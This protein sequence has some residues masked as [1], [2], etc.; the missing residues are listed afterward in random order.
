MDIIEDLKEYY[1]S[2]EFLQIKASFERVS[3]IQAVL[4]TFKFIPILIPGLLGNMVITIYFLKISMNRVGRMS[5]YHFL[6]VLLAI[7]D[8]VV[9]IL[10][11][12]SSILYNSI[13][14]QKLDAIVLIIFKEGSTTA[15]YWVL[16]MLSY[17]RY[18]RIVHHFKRKSKKRYV[19]LVWICLW[20][21]CILVHLPIS[22]A[23][24]KDPN[25]ETLEHLLPM[26]LMLDCILPSVFLAFF[27]CRISRFL[28]TA[29]KSIRV[30][31]EGTSS[32]A[33]VASST[34]PS[35]NRRS[36]QNAYANKTLRNLIIVY[37]CLV[38]PGQILYVVLHLLVKY[39]THLYIE[40]YMLFCVLEETVE[41]LVVL[42]NAVNVF[43][44]AIMITKFRSFLWRLVFCGRN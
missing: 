25:S 8:L 21:A 7:I 3:K 9:I 19:F 14:Y 33:V 29:N 6:I 11:T 16:L 41:I 12:V 43:V 38:W 31:N 1:T 26:H 39:K 37:I 22:I 40:N 24:F 10:G 36:Q 4:R 17:E 5:T 32:S 42:N 30:T 27:S 23:F 35:I 44:Y 13:Q 20:I 34:N 18:R 15:S 28:K 2:S